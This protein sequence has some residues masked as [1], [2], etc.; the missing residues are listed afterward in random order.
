MVICR[1]RDPH[2]NRSNLARHLNRLFALLAIGL[3][4]YV[5][6]P[7]ASEA[8]LDACHKHELARDAEKCHGALVAARETA[9]RTGQPVGIDIGPAGWV[10]GDGKSPLMSGKWGKGV[11][12]G[13]NIQGG[14]FFFDKDGNCLISPDAVCDGMDTQRPEPSAHVHEVA[15]TSGARR[16]YTIFFDKA[17]HP[18][19]G[20]DDFSE[21]ADTVVQK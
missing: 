17:G 16:I 2:L 9:L 14:R 5:L 6:A 4:I 3:G 10:V 18:L 8:M 20:H 13:T 7:V 12:V 1:K 15:I 11:M 21:P 19:I